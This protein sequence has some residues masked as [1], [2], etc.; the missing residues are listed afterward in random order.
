MEFA[1][2]IENY[3]PN[4]QTFAMNLPINLLSTPTQ[5]SFAM[6]G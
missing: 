3:M 2:L 5:I 6:V 1:I 4:I